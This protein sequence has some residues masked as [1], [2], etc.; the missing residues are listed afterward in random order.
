MFIVEPGAAKASRV[1]LVN[2]LGFATDGAGWVAQLGAEMPIV[3]RSG[4]K[5]GFDASVAIASYVQEARDA[6][7]P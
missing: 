2:K 6:A 1:T 7:K 3:I 4:L 5:S